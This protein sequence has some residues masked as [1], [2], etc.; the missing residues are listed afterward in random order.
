MAS[1]KNH[2]STL[3]NG[4]KK[5]NG[6]HNGLI[7]PQTLSDALA[8]VCND[9]EFVICLDPHGYILSINEAIATKFAQSRERLIGACM[10]D[11]LPPEVAQGRKA[12]VARVLETGSFIRLEDQNNGAWFDSIVYPVHN[13]QG[14]VSMIVII[15][16]DVTERWNLENNLKKINGSLEQLVEKRT[17]QLVEKNQ[18]LKT[19]A[20]RFEELNAAL[21]ILLEQRQKDKAELATNITANIDKM[22]IPNIEKLLNNN[23]LDALQRELLMIIQ[24]NLGQISSSFATTLSTDYLKLTPQQLQ[25]ANYIKEGKTTKEIAQFLGVSHR[26]I[27]VHRENIRKKLSLKKRS[28]N[29]RT[30][31]LC[32]H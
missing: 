2:T 22:I 11:L 6:H 18:E 25:I 14:V 17:A 9:T 21:R 10:W 24:S 13:A 31:L 1:I 7:K 27:E 5:Q 32:I 4:M 8:K 20:E 23:K 30:R 15:S 3:T 12:A 26:T 29:L 16:R 19:R 28:A